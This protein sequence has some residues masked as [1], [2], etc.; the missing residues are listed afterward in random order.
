MYH[1]MLVAI[2]GSISAALMPQN[3]LLFR[4]AL[5]R[6]VR[7]VM[8]AAATRFVNAYTVGLFADTDAVVG[9]FSSGSRMR[10]PHLELSDDIDVMLV[11]PATASVIA[12]VA[13]GECDGVVATTVAACRAPVV[14]VPSMNERLWD[15]PAV[16]RNV[17]LLGDLGHTVIEPTD[18]YE[19][20]N[21]QPT[22]DVMAPVERVLAHLAKLRCDDASEPADFG[23]S[24]LAPEPLTE[25]ARTF[26]VELPHRHART[27]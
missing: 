2:T 12:K 1:R 23:G 7:V 17:A 18:G 11:M 4:L 27:S 8:S 9:H 14:F 13:H 15:A 22:F 3:L 10:V 20:S 26:V 6:D 19:V 21:L 16:R 24:A 25:D 5:A